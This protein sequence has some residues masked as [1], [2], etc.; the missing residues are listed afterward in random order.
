M[1]IVHDSDGRVEGQ[2]HAKFWL[3]VKSDLYITIPK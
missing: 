3:R 2:I 1:R